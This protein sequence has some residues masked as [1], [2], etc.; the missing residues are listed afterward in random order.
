MENPIVKT[1][2]YQHYLNIYK[3]NLTK[4][5]S[6]PEWHFGGVESGIGFNGHHITIEEIKRMAERVSPIGPEVHID[7]VYNVTPSWK[8]LYETFPD[9]LMNFDYEKYQNWIDEQTDTFYYS[10]GEEN[11][12]AYEAYSIAAKLGYRKVIMEDLS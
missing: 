12:S 6:G 4:Y 5:Q 7:E 1:E 3:T 11:F 9:P 8:W 10:R 2:E